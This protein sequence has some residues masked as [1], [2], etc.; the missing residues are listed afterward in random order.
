MSQLKIWVLPFWIGDSGIGGLSIDRGY[1]IFGYRSP[2][3]FPGT[4]IGPSFDTGKEPFY[5]GAVKLNREG[6]AVW[7][8]SISQALILP[9]IITIN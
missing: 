9:L 8:Y 4:L 7:Q 6:T 1:V 2:M 3:D 5:S